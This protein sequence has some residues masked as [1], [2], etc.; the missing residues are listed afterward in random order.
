MSIGAKTERILSIYTKICEGIVVNKQEEALRYDVDERS[1]QRDLHDIRLFLDQRMVEEGKQNKVI[2]DKSSDGYRLEHSHNS[3]LSNSEML[4]ICKIL[5]ESR[6]FMKQELVPL[7]D[8]LLDSCMPK[9]DRKLL[10]QMIANEKHHYVEPQHK[11]VLGNKL[12]E[13]GSAVIEH[14]KLDLTY[15]RLKDKALVQRRV[16][17]VAV[18]FS[19]YYFYLAA[20]I[21]G[22][23]DRKNDHSPTIYR[24]D[25]IH[26]FV[27]LEERFNIPYKDRFEEGKFLKRVQFMFGGELKQIKFLYKGASVEHVLDRLPTAKIIDHSDGIYTLT[28]EVFGTG[29]DMWLR[30]QGDLIEICT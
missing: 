19:E 9:K 10:T 28:A 6:A 26:S 30:S 12:W 23:E 22:D 27:L 11:T 25:R 5:L 17:P 14:R 2:L 4:A 16:R 29:I 24:I 1:I 13:L 7:L 8:K 18:L 21:D 3:A 20:F 15:Q